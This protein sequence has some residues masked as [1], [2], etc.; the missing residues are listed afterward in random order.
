M[1][2][3]MYDRALGATYLNGLEAIDKCAKMLNLSLK[4]DENAY[5]RTALYSKGLCKT[6]EDFRNTLKNLLNLL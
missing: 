2:G 5:R 4:E 3:W 6:E 1:P